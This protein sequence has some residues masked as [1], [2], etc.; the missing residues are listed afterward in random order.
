MKM[1]MVWNVFDKCSE[2]GDDMEAETRLV[3]FPS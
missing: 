3:Q 2:P 1:N